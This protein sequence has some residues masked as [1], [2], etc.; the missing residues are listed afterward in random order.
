M[1]ATIRWVLVR[2]PE[3]RRDPQAFFTTDVTLQPTEIVAFFVR[4]WQ[5]EVTFAE[6][7]AHLGGETQRQWSTK[8][9]RAQRPRYSVYTV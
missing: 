6:T 8:L 4:R 9:S 3:D 2:D 1:P 7:R 5:V